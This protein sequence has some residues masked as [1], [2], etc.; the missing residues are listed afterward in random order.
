MNELDD[1]WSQM[2]EKA[3]ASTDMAGRGD[4]AEYLR[5]K[6][7]NDAIRRRSIQWLFDSVI[8]LATEADPNFARFKMERI[9]PHN[10]PFRGANMAGSLLRV[11]QG[12]RCL[13]IE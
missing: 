1:I 8:E 6:A 12:V 3:I 9:E 5:L 4:V 2:L 11:R 7:T 13:T 10:F